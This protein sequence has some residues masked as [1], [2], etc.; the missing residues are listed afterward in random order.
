MGL[1]CGPKSNDL[2]A[3]TVLKSKTVLWNG[4]AGVFE[5]P[6]FA[7]GTTSLL[8]ACATAFEAGATTIVGGGDTAT[9][10]AQ[11]GRE[12]EFSHVSTGGG[13]SL[14]LLEGKALPGVVALS[15]K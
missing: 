11:A 8:D 12:G 3:A 13:A 14:E 9:A 4:P 5:F 15:S 2:F 7:T 1:D 6:A 10:V